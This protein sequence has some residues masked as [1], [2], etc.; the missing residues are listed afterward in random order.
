MEVF[1]IE[2]RE[3]VL[4][5]RR[6]FVRSHEADE[7][8]PCVSLYENTRREDC[9]GNLCCVSERYGRGCRVSTPCCF[10]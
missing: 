10:L 6:V 2:A 4:V 7:F 1:T 3:E 8:K 5:V 9:I